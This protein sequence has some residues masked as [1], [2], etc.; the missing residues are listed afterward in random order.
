ML[1][2]I[3]KY[4]RTQHI[5]GSRS[6]PGD[7]DLNNVPFK[8]ISN[9]FVVVE[10]KVDGANCGISF[11]E[12]GELLLQSR[13]HYL[14]GGGRERHFNLF[15]TWANIHV[16]QLWNILEDR[17]I[18]YGEWLYAK[19]TVFYDELSHYFMEFDIYDKVENKFLSTEARRNMLKDYSFINSVFVLF[20]GKLNSLK[21]LTA[22]I[23][24]SNFIS[25][26]HNSKLKTICSEN[27]LSLE[28]VLKET[29]NSNI[30]EGLYI[31]V[32][33]DGEVKERYKYVRSS[34]LT[35]ILNSE[36]HWLDRPI[37]PNVLKSG[38]DIFKLE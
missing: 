8:R 33:E 9:R 22:F 34:F 7:E 3:L 17:Y 32:E 26:N 20:E 1:N 35:N 23:D 37:V 30:M 10:E 36:T 11:S 14:T 28:Q 38:V 21:E 19:H 12:G 29:D 6:Q 2:E 15:K 16:S 4:P 5:E 13:G 24:K 27:G 25:A 18:M 31:K